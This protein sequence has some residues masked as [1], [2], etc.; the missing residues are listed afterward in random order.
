M[1]N[2]WN[3]L[4]SVLSM[5][6]AFCC[7]AETAVLKAEI[8]LLSPL[9]SLIAAQDPCAPSPCS[10]FAVC[11]VLGLRKYQCTCKEGFQGDGKIC[12]PINPCVESNGGCPENSTICVY[13]RPGE[14]REITASRQPE[15]IWKMARWGVLQMS[16]PLC[17]S[18]LLSSP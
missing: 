18:N 7:A 17:W 8:G 9:I 16:W 15:R 5:P 1:S 2:S 4:Y 10:P 14:V 13:R 6:F 11:K 3:S 12:Q